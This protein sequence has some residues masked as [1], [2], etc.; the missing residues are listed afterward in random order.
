MRAAPDGASS[1]QEEAVT[2]IVVAAAAVLFALALSACASK[3]APVEPAPAPAPQPAPA[4]QPAPQPAPPAPAPAVAAPQAELDQARASRERVLKFKLEQQFPQEFAAAEALLRQGEGNMNRDNAAARTAIVAAGAGY[5]KILQDGLTPMARRSRQDVETVRNNAMAIKAQV[6]MQSE[7]ATAEASY[8]KAV[9]AEGGG[10][11]EGALDSYVQARDQFAK[12]YE[13]TRV[14][15]DRAERALA[16]ARR[17]LADAEA[18]A[19][20]AEDAAKAEAAR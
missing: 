14:K 5:R 18:R 1:R 11:L 17:G 15:M 10:D 6:A 8:Q 12:V 19:K 13:E 16:D 3:P 20:T 4:V 9:A 7:Y 2:R